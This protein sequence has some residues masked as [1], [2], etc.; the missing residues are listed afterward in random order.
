M[1]ASK[2]VRAEGQLPDRPRHLRANYALSGFLEPCAPGSG[3]GARDTGSLPPGSSHLGG[4]ADKIGL[5][6]DQAFR[7]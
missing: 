2:A 1:A 5:P 3:Q 4:E 6:W 7:V